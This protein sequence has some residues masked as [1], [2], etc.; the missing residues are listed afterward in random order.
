MTTP[1]I[2]EAT[3]HD[4]VSDKD[5]PLYAAARASHTAIMDVSVYCEQ[6]GWHLTSFHAVGE[7]RAK[8]IWDTV[9]HDEI[10]GGVEY[11]AGF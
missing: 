11:D 2:Y 9:P 6:K 5:V 10:I 1:D 4:P 7:N 3:A 8:K